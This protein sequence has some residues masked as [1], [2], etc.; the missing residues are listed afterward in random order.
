MNS[1]RVSGMWRR[2]LYEVRVAANPAYGASEESLGE[3][4]AHGDGLVASG[5]VAAFTVARVLT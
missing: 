1:G 2:T 4:I 3:A 5:G